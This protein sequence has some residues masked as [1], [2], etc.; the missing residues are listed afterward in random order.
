MCGIYGLFNTDAGS[1]ID[2]E[3]LRRMGEALIHRGPDGGGRY[4]AGPVGMGMRRLS[5]IDLKTGDQ[6]IANEDRTVW[7]VFNGEIYNFREL[8]AELI[9]KGHQ[10]ATASD[11]EV[12]V[13]LYEEHGEE[14]VERLR[15]MFAFA[16]WDARRQTLFLARDRVG[17]KPLYYAE[18]PQ[19][20]AF[21]SELKAVTRSPRVGRTVSGPALTAYL[22]FGYVP[23]PLSILDGVR[24]LPPGHTLSVRHG[25]AGPPRPYWEPT[26]FFATPGTAFGEGEAGDALWDLLRDAVRSHLVSDV[27]LGAFLSGG[28][29]STMVVSLMAREV[30]A[31]IKTFSVGF[32]EGPF[33]ELPY[34]RR[35][36][37]WLGA[38]HHE[39]IMGPGDLAGLD[40]V[41]SMFDEPFADASALPTYLVSRLARQHVKV[42]LSGDGGDELFAGYDRYLVDHRLRRLGR[43]GDLGLGGGLRAL[44]NVLP[45]GTPGKNFLYALSLP[46]MERYISMISAFPPRILVDFVDPELVAASRVV[47]NQQVRASDGLDPLSR[48]QD[49]DIRTYLPG[50]ILTKVDRMSMANSLEARVPLLDH[51]VIEFA[52]GVPAALRFRSGQ[53]KYLLRRVLR[54]K[55][56]SEVLTRPKHGFG[57]PL[58]LWFANELPGFIRDR[59]GNGSGLATAGINRSSVRAL[60]ERYDR[61][62]RQDDC[63]RLWA[64]MV[65]ECALAHL[66]D[67]ASAATGR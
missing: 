53:L 28:I 5:I 34:A 46:R 55:V 48:L 43:L 31:P 62:R 3:V 13:H 59:L 26:R 66:R 10:F 19:E 30:A 45:P 36:A 12:L 14:C 9:G 51:R 35:V 1:P 25:R 49:L 4:T 21:A 2:R 27:P 64:L 56:P 6:P 42:V 22:Q 39:L 32:R 8:T 20:F 33:N 15:G 17:I 41:L 50:D 7:V 58:E 23:D 60:M 44:S 37:D 54:D 67:G 11:T 52:C 24:K 18:T 61:Q 47:F 63:Q 38:E 29:D 40:E 57:V 65:L 16:I